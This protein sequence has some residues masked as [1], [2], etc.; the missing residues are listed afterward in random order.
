MFE[1]ISDKQVGNCDQT[2]LWI[3]LTVSCETEVTHFCALLIASND[4]LLP[5][6]IASIVDDHAYLETL[7]INLPNDNL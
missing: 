4:E 1:R 7:P 2:A 6:E 3:L 5:N